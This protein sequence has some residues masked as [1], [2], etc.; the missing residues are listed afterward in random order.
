MCSKERE[1]I[2][3]GIDSL[4]LDSGLLSLLIYQPGFDMNSKFDLRGVGK[5][6]TKNLKDGENV[7]EMKGWQSLKHIMKC[8]A[9]LN[10]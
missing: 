9:K 6:L 10:S 4:N 8:E 5:V 2:K 3:L 7:Q 1:M